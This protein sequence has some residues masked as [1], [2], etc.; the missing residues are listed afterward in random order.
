ML[1]L[2]DKHDN[3]IMITYCERF[4]PFGKCSVELIDIVFF[5]FMAS[6]LLVP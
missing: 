3:I 5:R 6:L 2:L 1:D 4:V